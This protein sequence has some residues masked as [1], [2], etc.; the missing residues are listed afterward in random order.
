MKHQPE[1]ANCR[2]LRVTKSGD[3]WRFEFI[4][5]ILLDHWGS[6]QLGSSV[7]GAPF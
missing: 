5:F 2:P 1:R 7:L 6:I 4:V 3:V